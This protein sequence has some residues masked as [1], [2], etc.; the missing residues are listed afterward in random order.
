MKKRLAIV[1]TAAG[2]IAA[3]LPGIAS[4]APCETGRQ[5]AE[6]HIVPLAQAG[7]LGT[8]HKPGEHQG[9]ANVPDVCS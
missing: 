8:G 2:L 9:F 5:Y 6:T 7:V 1:V 3:M 4:A